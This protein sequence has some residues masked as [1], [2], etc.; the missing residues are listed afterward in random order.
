MLVVSLSDTAKPKQGKGEAGPGFTHFN[1]LPGVE[2]AALLRNVLPRSG[3]LLADGFNWRETLSVIY[4]TTAL[5]L[6]VVRWWAS[7]EDDCDYEKR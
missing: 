3:S 1:R 6:R 4:P 2:E 7:V 5:R